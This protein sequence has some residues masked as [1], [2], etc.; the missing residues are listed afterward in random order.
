M[1]HFIFLLE[2]K[3]DCDY[4]DGYAKGQREYRVGKKKSGRGCVKACVRMM[5]RRPTLNINGVSYTT[6]F[7]ACYCQTGMTSRSNNRIWKSC[8]LIPSESNIEQSRTLS[9]KELKAR[10]IG[11][12]CFCIVLQFHS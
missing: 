5:K 7:K 12:S 4:K 2:L 9:P 8:Y 10:Q 3:Y 6:R 1:F 11:K